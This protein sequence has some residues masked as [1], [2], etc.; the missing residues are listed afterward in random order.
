MYDSLSVT[1]RT[2]IYGR[3]DVRLIYGAD[4]TDADYGATKQM[5][6]MGRATRQM[7]IM[8]RATRQMLFMMPGDRCLNADGVC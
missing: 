2:L 6:I 5:L 8:G 4:R 1:G 3:E 7:L